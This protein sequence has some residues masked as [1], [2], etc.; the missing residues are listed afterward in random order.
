MA[1]LNE[2]KARKLERVASEYE[3]LK[4]LEAQVFNYIGTT[5]PD[6]VAEWLRGAISEL[7]QHRIREMPQ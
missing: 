3:H 7:S 2:L 1:T 6:E 5:D 4:A